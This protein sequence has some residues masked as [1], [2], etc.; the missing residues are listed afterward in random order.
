[1]AHQPTSVY[2]RIEVENGKIVRIVT[3]EYDK[4][5]KGPYSCIDV[6]KEDEDGNA[7]RRNLY[8]SMWGGYVVMFP[9]HPRNT[10]S[11][12]YSY[13]PSIAEE[14]DWEECSRSL[15]GFSRTHL[16]DTERG[17][18]IMYHYDFKY[19]FNKYCFR[20]LREVMDKLIIWKQHPELELMLAAGFE[21]L[22]MNKQLYRMKPENRK[23]VMKFCRN[24]PDACNL[25]YREIRLC[26]KSD[27]PDLMIRYFELVPTWKRTGW[28]RDNYH[29]SSSINIAEFTYLDRKKLASNE[30]VDMYCDYMYML[31]RSNHNTDDPYW[32]FP[33]NLKKQHDKLLEEE[34][35]EREAKKRAEEE[36][37]AA[38]MKKRD[39]DFQKVCKKYKKYNSVVGDYNIYISTDYDDWKKQADAL[40]QCIVY[41]DYMK[42][43]AERRCL[44]VFIR[45]GDEPIATAEILPGKKLGQFYGNEIDRNNCKPSEEVQQVFN[46]WL[47]KV[48]VKEAI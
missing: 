7:W 34:R 15:F 17:N 27:N 41:A 44:I 29:S 2:D 4:A 1:M 14:E 9:G 24:N 28:S 47:E 33:Q 38:E 36:R 26:M 43:V 46:K 39:S 8:M 21:K 3:A 30:G 18:I 22:G 12:S 40:H 31:R 16:N 11:Y 42:H 20:N 25:N 6:Y 45:K 19:V 13:D 37:K 48:T 35:I 32:H 5:G 23:E 10:T